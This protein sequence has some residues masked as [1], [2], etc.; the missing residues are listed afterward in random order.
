[1]ARILLVEDEPWFGELYTRLL[2]REHQV[3]WC[4]DGYQA[5][6]AVDSR[7]DVIVLDI[8]LPWSN[9]V[10]LL[11]ELAGYEDTATIPIILFSA[12]LPDVSEDILRP[13]GVVAALDKTTV[14]PAQVL[15]TI[16]GV[17]KIHADH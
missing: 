9:G 17:I 1:M 8:L 5:I 3:Q 7:P 2:S 16:N 13:Y 12:A 15:K 10:Q 11:H 14:K 6:M 4:R